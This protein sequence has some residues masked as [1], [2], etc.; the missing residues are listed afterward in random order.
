MRPFRSLDFFSFL[1]FFLSPSSL[2]SAFLFL[3]LCLLWYLVK[4]PHT[5]L[6]QA[7]QVTW[8]NSTLYINCRRV[9]RLV[10]ALFLVILCFLF[11]FSSFSFFF[12][13]FCRIRAQIWHS[14]EQCTCP[15]VSFPSIPR[16]LLVGFSFLFVFVDF[17]ILF[18]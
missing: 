12:I 10:V 3:R 9:S 2:L 5:Q 1:L 6:G 16:P 18:I 13:W 7:L 15:P 8:L 17:M 4:P 11:D 14:G